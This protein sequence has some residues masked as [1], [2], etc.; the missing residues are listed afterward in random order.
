MKRKVPS[1]PA[2][3]L[4]KWMRQIGSDEIAQTEGLPLRRDMV[5]LLT[6]IRDNR[7]TGTQSTGNLPLKAVREVTARFVHPPILDRTIGDHVFKLRSEDDVW[8]LSFLHTLAYFG[9]LLN[10]GPARRW[11][12]TP[13]GEKFLIAPSPVQLWL[14]LST[15]WEQ[16]DWLIAFPFTGMGESLPPRFTQVTLDHLRAL[17]INTAVTF[18]PFADKLIQETGLKWSAPDL[19]SAQS[20]LRWS[21]RRMVISILV[22]FGVVEP[23]HQ[24][25]PLGKGTTKELVA[26]QIT[27][28]GKGLLEALEM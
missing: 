25:K 22:D 14:L 12:L 7:I 10:G 11:R 4:D 28:F 21:I 27:S 20:S 23:E 9:G 24:D 1:S 15:W 8:S 26:F 3:R 5:T 18:E 2:P 16:V 17:P 19:S 6:Y 13:L